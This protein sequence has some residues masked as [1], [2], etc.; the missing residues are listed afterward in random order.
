MSEVEVQHF[1]IIIGTVIPLLGMLLIKLRKR[2]KSELIKEILEDNNLLKSETKI[3]IRMNSIQISRYKKVETDS[4]RKIPRILEEE[5]GERYLL[6]RKNKVIRLKKMK[7]IPIQEGVYFQNI[8][9]GKIDEFTLDKINNWNGLF[10]GAESGTGKSEL[11]RK[12]IEGRNT[13]VYSPK[14]SEDFK[15]GQRFNEQ[16][17]RDIDSFVD[18]FKN[19][20]TE[21]II[22]IDEIIT[23]VSLV[24]QL[25]KNLLRKMSINF[26]L[27][28]SSNLKWIIMTQKL[29]RMGDLDLSLL[30]YKI[31]NV[32]SIALYKES[33]GVVPKTQMANLK[34][35]QF[36]MMKEGEEF[37]IQNNISKSR[38]KEL[39]YK[40]VRKNRIE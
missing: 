1:T 32:P 15:N 24:K 31:L 39:G 30:N 33:L 23:F 14:G 10:I 20:K 36:V 28:R 13:L 37:L 5:T 34:K 19:I 21:T 2:S 18:N 9:T 7:K 8:E 29:N 38:L 35:G 40:G 22:V 11:V 26:T 3:I 17:V 16:M 6:E 4:I 27:N 25:N 12:L